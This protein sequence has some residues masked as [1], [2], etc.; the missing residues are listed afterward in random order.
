MKVYIFGHGLKYSNPLKTPDFRNI[1]RGPKDFT[2]LNTLGKC[3]K[4]IKFKSPM[5]C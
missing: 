3:L 5:G 1:V 2:Q 4:A